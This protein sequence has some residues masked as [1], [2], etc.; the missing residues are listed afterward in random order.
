MSEGSHNRWRRVMA[1][2]I[3]VLIVIGLVLL[4][5][6]SVPTPRAATGERPAGSDVLRVGALPVT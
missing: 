4:Y 3:P 5:R 6:V 1:L 2:A